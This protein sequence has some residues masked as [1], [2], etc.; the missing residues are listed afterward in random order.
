MIKALAV[1]VAARIPGTTEA[2]QGAMPLT[3]YVQRAL[4]QTRSDRAWG[5]Q[6]IKRRVG[7]L[8]GREF[9]GRISNSPGL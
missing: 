2:R 7:L 4:S 9:W 5:L 3:A 8:D 1:R 6:F